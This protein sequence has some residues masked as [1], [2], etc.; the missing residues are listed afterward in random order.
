MKASYGSFIRNLSISLETTDSV[1]YPR[2]NWNVKK[3]QD[4]IGIFNS[5]TKKI[6]K[7]VYLK[8]LKIQNFVFDLSTCWDS[9]GIGY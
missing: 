1:I 2:A 4:F 8:E 6:D 5:I 7:N 3:I 9:E